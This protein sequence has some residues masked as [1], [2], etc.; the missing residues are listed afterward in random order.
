MPKSRYYYEARHGRGLRINFDPL[1]FLN[2][3][4]MHATQVFWH[5]TPIEMRPLWPRFDPM[6][7]GIA[8]Q[9]QRHQATTAGNSGFNSMFPAQL[10]FRISR[11]NFTR[12]VHLQVLCKIK[13]AQLVHILWWVAWKCERKTGTAMCVPVSVGHPCFPFGLSMLFFTVKMD[14][15]VHST[16]DSRDCVLQPVMLFTPNML[17]LLNN[18]A[19]DEPQV[20]R[21]S[22]AKQKPTPTWPYG[23]TW[24]QRI[25]TTLSHAIYITSNNSWMHSFAEFEINC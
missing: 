8:V 15:T 13:Q 18:Y 4:S 9:R 25:H 5:F 1:G 3:H 21:G 11:E 7:S 12:T 14:D 6:H 20:C 22:K 19:T 17:L 24:K 10:A 23:N 16:P 2:V